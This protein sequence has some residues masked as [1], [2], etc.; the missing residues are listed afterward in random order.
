MLIVNLRYPKSAA[1][2]TTEPAEANTQLS[3]VAFLV[4][5]GSER[6]F[7]PFATLLRL[8]GKRSLH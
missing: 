8:H 1:K 2:H 3:F 4:N 6:L 5:I 7:R